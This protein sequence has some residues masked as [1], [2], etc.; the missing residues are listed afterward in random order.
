MRMSLL[1]IALVVGLL[2]GC[3]GEPP[4]P[5]PAAPLA[6]S[7]DA[8]TRI[9]DVT[10]RATVMPT[11]MLGEL[12]AAK[13]DIPRADNQIMLMVGLRRGGEGLETS[14]P[15]KIV[16]TASDLRG[17]RTTI[18][19]RELTSESLVDYLGI[20]PVTLPD[21]LKF[22]LDITLDDGARTTLQFTREFPRD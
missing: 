6:D 4:S 11:A 8:V 10:V 5:V 12:V 16:A 13:Y 15:A 1:P 9:G 18:G 14:V 17:K 20:V 3:G 7:Q 19:L 22:D 21:T 2:A